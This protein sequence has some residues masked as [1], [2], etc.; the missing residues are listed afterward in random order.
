MALGVIWSERA[1]KGFEEII[2]YLEKRWTEKEISN[3][4]QDVD[5]FLKLLE[6]NPN[7]L[8]SSGK[9]NLYRGPINR[10]TIVTYQVK[11]RKRQIYLVNIRS[12]RKKPLL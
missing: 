12:A 11:P 2:E 10:L 9:K 8:K 6:K 1:E 3:F 4:I 5:S 7:M